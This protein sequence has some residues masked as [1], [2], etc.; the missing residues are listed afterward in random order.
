MP[1]LTPERWQE[2]S[3]Y[4][5]QLLSLPEEERSAWLESFRAQQPDLAALLQ[6]LLAEH[7]ALAEEH[8]LEESVVQDALAISRT[9]TKIPNYTLIS[10][11][12]Q[13]GMGTVWL[14]ERNDGRFERRVA[15]KLLHFS[16]T[17][18]GGVE[19]FKREGILGQLVHPHIAELL[20]AGVTPGGEPYLVLENV[21][22]EHIDEYCDRRHLDVNARIRLFLDVLDAVAYAHAHLIVHRD[23]KPGNVLVRNDGRVK[24]L[25]FGIAKLLADDSNAA[26]AT[27]LTLE[28]G[29]A[30]TPHFAAPEQ[31]RGEAITT[32]TDVYGVGVLLYILLTGRHPAGSSSQSPAELVKAIVDREPP[33]AS[34]AVALSENNS[35]AGNRATTS[36]KLRHKLRGDLDT[37]VAK[38]L[39]KVPSER[40]YSIT[41]LAE[42][43]RRYLKH[44]PISAK[45]DTI[46]YR[47]RKFVRRNRIPVALTA[48]I[49]IAVVAGVAG[50]L[51]QARNARAQRDFAYRQLSRA[52]AV[53]DLNDFLLSDAAPSGKP[54]TVD[55]LLGRAE[56]II[57]R[58]RNGDANQVELLISIGRQYT[59]E[60]ERSKALPL[61]ERAYSLS[62]T[63]S[64]PSARSK[65]SCALGSALSITGDLPRAEALLQEGLKELPD[66]PQFTLDRV[67]CLSRGSEVAENRGDSQGTFARTLTAQHLLDSSVFRS[68]LGDLHLLITLAEAYRNSGQ[69]GKA[70][71]TFEEAS[72]LET[73][74]GREDTENAGTIYNDWA[75]ALFQAG[76]PLESEPLFRRAIEISRADATEQAVSP[77][78]LLNYGR[79]LRELGQLD[80]AADYAE[81]AYV[82]GQ[83]VG[84]QV[85]INQSLI[86]RARIYRGMGNLDRAS[87][88]L[89]EVEPRLRQALPPKHYAFAGIASERSL[90]SLARGDLKNALALANSA[91]ANDEAAIQSGGQGAGELPIFLFRRSTIELALG[92]PGDAV[93]SANRAVALLQ[94]AQQPGTFSCNL[95][96]AYLAE[97]RALEAQSKY[98][99]ANAAFHS[100]AEN[101]QNT[102]GS[103]HSETR[104]AQQFADKLGSFR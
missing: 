20:D 58:Q 88:M 69:Y 43:L 54:F 38:T 97:G 73:S 2:V 95:G 50:I 6:D 57:A 79:T 68:D 103:S 7:R 48:L 22:G 78:L 83:K 3:P 46:I 23:I 100:A 93:A 85:V 42:D 104:T 1:T 16:L 25:D 34:A 13:G 29:G 84:H 75:L 26:A 65:A 4:L 8:F 31:V 91:V 47:A 81:R 101:L 63:L 53:N 77:M 14:A 40:Y 32:S 87:E 76:R 89:A 90:I 86:E 30:L 44:E 72:R 56:R 24:L 28:A 49:L 15:V 96:R 36:E 19:R 66:S 55:E 41:A 27:M 39:K 60:D 98:K 74:L 51:V 67:F 92:R 102:L 35:L 62:R 59:S 18:Q 11:I 10:P 9:G 82:G 12:G 99:E 64:D 45:P 17:A 37:I 71:I 5:D 94:S 80:K 21:E 61:L 70:I 33:A 52:E